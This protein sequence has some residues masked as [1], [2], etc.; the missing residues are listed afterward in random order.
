[1]E[2]PR[3]SNARSCGTILAVDYF[4]STNNYLHSLRDQLYQCFLEQQIILRPLGNTVYIVPPY[5]ITEDELKKVYHAM[6]TVKFD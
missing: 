4:N 2:N 3:C 6:E 1:R 5:C